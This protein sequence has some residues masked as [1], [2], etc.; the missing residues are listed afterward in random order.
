M[1]DRRKCAYCDGNGTVP[2]MNSW[3]LSDG[4]R[5]GRCGICRGTGISDYR[6]S[7]EAMA[8][9]NRMRAL[10]SLPVPNSPEAKES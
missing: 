2:L 4:L 1:S 8:S 9:V 3:F 6:P 7:Y 10:A 5:Q